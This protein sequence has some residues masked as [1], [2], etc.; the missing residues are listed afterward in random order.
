MKII[1]L[2][3]AYPFTHMASVKYFD[4][5]NIQVIV[6]YL[7]SHLGFAFKFHFAFDV[8]LFSSDLSFILWKHKL[9]HMKKF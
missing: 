2:L 8:V 7:Y 5:K 1:I 9:R 4:Y 6:Y 3:E